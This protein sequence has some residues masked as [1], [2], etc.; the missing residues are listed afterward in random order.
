MPMIKVM[1]ERHVKKGQDPTILSLELG[2]ADAMHY[3]GYA[4]G[5]RLVSTE[6]SSIIITMSTW[7]SIE[8]WEHWANSETRAQLHQ[9][10]APFLRGK[11][12]TR[13]FKVI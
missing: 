8:D 10:I 3:K 9:K 7:H 2:L 4:G 11:P 5:E 1:I 12:T 6:N 13:I